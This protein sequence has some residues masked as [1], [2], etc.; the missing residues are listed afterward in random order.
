[1]KLVAL[2]TAADL[3]DGMLDAAPPPAPGGDPAAQV[4]SISPVLH[5]DHGLASHGPRGKRK[6]HR[7]EDER[8]RAPIVH[9]SRAS[10]REL[11]L[12]R[13]PFVIA[14]RRQIERPR[15]NGAARGGRDPLAGE[16]T[17]THRLGDRGPCTWASS[18]DD[19]RGTRREARR[20]GRRRTPRVTWG[21]TRCTPSPAEDSADQRASR[22]HGSCRGRGLGVLPG[23]IRAAQTAGQ[24]HRAES[25][26]TSPAISGKGAS[27]PLRPSRALAAT[28][29]SEDAPSA[30]DVVGTG[31]RRGTTGR[32]ARTSRSRRGMIASSRRRDAATAAARARDDAARRG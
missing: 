24:G 12:A 17:R 20:R 31:R 23:P 13:L 22:R 2:E 18:R 1:M 32:T 6:R 3:S 30:R 14:T 5:D 15:Q 19:P 29:V 27:N 7:R 10:S 9:T 25:V 11:V 21:W 16:P 28:G 4:R 8:H 26:A